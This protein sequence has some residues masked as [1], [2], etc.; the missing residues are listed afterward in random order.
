M[1]VDKAEN[2]CTENTDTEKGEDDDNLLV[3][4]IISATRNGEINKYIFPALEEF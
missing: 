2:D 3:I 1:N 4:D